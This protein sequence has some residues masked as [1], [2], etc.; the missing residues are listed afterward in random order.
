M[1]EGI[2]RDL[3]SWDADADVDP[4]EDRGEATEAIIERAD[5]AYGERFG[6]TASEEEAGESLDQRLAEERPDR[7]SDEFGVAIEDGEG[8]EDGQ[9]AG[10]VSS[11]RDP[12]IAPEDAAVTIRRTAPGGTDHMPETEDIE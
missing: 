11:E 6:T 1:D 5:G 8:E 9:L 3:P 2:S 4:D 7:R 12:F 10:E